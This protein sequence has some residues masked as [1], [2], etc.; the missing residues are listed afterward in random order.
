MN[1]DGKKRPA[2]RRVLTGATAGAWALLLGAAA[3]WLLV[4]TDLWPLS[5]RSEPAT[6]VWAFNA[7]V[8]DWLLQH[9]EA[10]WRAPPEPARESFTDEEWSKV[11]AQLARVKP[12]EKLPVHGQMTGLQRQN[13]ALQASAP[14]I[15]VSVGGGGGGGGGGRGGGGG[16]GGGRGGG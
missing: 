3:L 16:G 1:L 10:E 11:T 4:T 15:S 14:S 12:K 7:T 8:G 6:S 5:G 13:S 2:T 9:G